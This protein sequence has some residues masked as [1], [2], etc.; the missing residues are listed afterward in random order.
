MIIVMVMRYSYIISVGHVIII[1]IVTSV[2]ISSTV[3]FRNF[4][5]IFWPRP[6]HIE[7]R[8]RF[9]KTSTIKLSGFETLILKIRRL[10][11]WKPTVIDHIDPIHTIQ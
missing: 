1:I 8:H 3:G 7:I 2:T 6:W 4:I 9:N 10:K 5:V 11:L